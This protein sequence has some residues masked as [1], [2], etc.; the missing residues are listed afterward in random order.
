MRLAAMLRQQSDTVLTTVLVVLVAGMLVAAPAAALQQGPSATAQAQVGPVQGGIIDRVLVRV[1][2]EAILFSEFEA[3]LQE[4]LSAIA[5]QIPQ[6][7][8]DAQLPQLRL[9][10][11]VALV[12]EALLKIRAGEL[13]IIADPNEIDRAIMNIRES[14]GLVDDNLWRQALAEN[15]LT[16]A[17]MRDNASEAIVQQR[18]MI[19]EIQRQVFVSQREVQTY[20]EE[21]TAQFSEPEQVLFQQLVFAFQGADRA[22]VRTRAENALTELRAGISLSAVGNKYAR[23]NVDVVQDAA[24]AS[25]I[26]PEDIQGTVRAVI[27]TLTPLAYSDIVEAT[28]GV[29]ILQLMDRR[30]GRVVPL[31]EVEGLIRNQ[32]TDQKMGIRLEEYTGNLMRNASL[33]IYAEEF[34]DL[35]N[36][37]SE[38][39]RGAPTGPAREQR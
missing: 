30:E 33:E 27:E 36:A 12:E 18:M 24:G 31:E 32:L 35:S 7:Q 19:Q 37:W 26:S 17:Q 11:M 20:Y 6:D 39:S 13:G 5:G 16:E 9:T 1:S 23:P 29:H 3:Q 8:I 21:N 34:D 2:G 15:G 38:E 10:L 25:W 28:F 22:E 4:R 14:S